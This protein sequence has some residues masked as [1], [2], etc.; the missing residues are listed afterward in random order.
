M[1][2]LGGGP[3]QA[4]K[5]RNQ[6]C[7][8]KHTAIH[9]IHKFSNSIDLHGDS[10]LQYFKDYC[11]H[12]P[13]NQM[14]D[15]IN[16]LLTE[17]SLVGPKCTIRSII[18]SYLLDRVSELVYTETFEE[19]TAVSWEQWGQHRATWRKQAGKS[20]MNADFSSQ[21]N[22]TLGCQWIMNALSSVL[23]TESNVGDLASDHA[24]VLGSRCSHTGVWCCCLC[25]IYPINRSKVR[26]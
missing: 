16:S 12:I 18:S 1:S 25:N 7:F 11:Q 17:M 14:K 13:S 2:D 24:G 15:T 9:H 21:V 6:S 10:H 8:L 23:Q 19:Y 22:I 20:G 4:D 3:V 26:K 5:Q